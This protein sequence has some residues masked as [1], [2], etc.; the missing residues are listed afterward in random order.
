TNGVTI[1]YT[2]TYISNVIPLP[3]V[4]SLNDVET[5][6]N[7]MLQPLV[8]GNYFTG[9]NGTGTALFAGDM[10][11]SAQ[12]VYIYSET[13]TTPNCF[14]ESSFVIT[15][16]SL[17][18]NNYSETKCDDLNDGNE[19]IDLS[20][21]NAN[22]VSVPSDCTFEYYSSLA[23][24]TNQTSTELVSSISNYNLTIGLHTIY[25][26]IT[27]NRGCIQIAQLDLTLVSTPIITI[28]DI[29]PICENDNI[30]VDAGLGFDSYL[31]STGETSQT[32]TVSQAGNYSV[33]VTED[34]GSIDCSS[35]KH[36][37]VVLSNI[38]TITN[39]ETQDWTNTE[40][41]ITVN[42][43]GFGNYE[44][45]ID[46]IHYQ[47]S[48]VFSGLNCGEYTVYVRDKNGCGI[49][50][51]N[52]FLLMYPK[53]FTPN[54]DGYNDTWSIKFSWLEP[55]LKVTIFDRYGK[56]LKEL[57]NSDS[58]DGKYNGHELPSTDYW[59]VVTRANGKEYRE[60]FTLKR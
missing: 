46:G 32:I 45:S 60:H 22:L 44:Y 19:V 56:F 47:D 36:F 33:T 23:G 27:S 5:C 41:I 29:V 31:W 34:Y 26:R 57:I 4:D 1:P 42:T 25:I 7:Y 35:T 50:T 40:N 53:F 21:Y 48:N 16:N 49:T 9:Q 8:N 52:I 54:G 38:A 43:T 58:W 6:G 39:I 13:G 55:G 59:F 11:T 2:V 18:T 24:A 37:N 10:I 12:T 3:I 30:I 28:P 20:S 51:E 17:S 14:A 15:T